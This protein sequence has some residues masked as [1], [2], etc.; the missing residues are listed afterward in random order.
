[1]AAERPAER[2]NSAEPRKRGRL[3]LKPKILELGKWTRDNDREARQSKK[4]GNW[5][6]RGAR[7]LYADTPPNTSR[8]ASSSSAGQAE[9]RPRGS[10]SSRADRKLFKSS[11]ITQI[12]E[13]GRLLCTKGVHLPPRAG[14]GGRP[15]P[16]RAAGDPEREPSFRGVDQARFGAL[17]EEQQRKHEKR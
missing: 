9:H 13:S 14:G 4:A 3:S 12:Q 17:E 5:T 6:S 2:P 1:M 16:S 10:N 7:G 11:R 15:L 8:F